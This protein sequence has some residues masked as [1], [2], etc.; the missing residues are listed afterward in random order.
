MESILKVLRQT[1]SG[2]LSVLGYATIYVFAS[3]GM[4]VLSSAVMVIG[5]KGALGTGLLISIGMVMGAAVA[6]PGLI[7][8]GMFAR[9]LFIKQ[10]RSSGLVRFFA[11]VILLPHSLIALA[12]AVA[13]V[14]LAIGTSGMLWEMWF[15]ESSA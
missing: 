4:V 9:G 14:L 13:F 8:A 2:E 7:A 5:M 12:A 3:F 10:A 1:W 6:I 11:W 15:E